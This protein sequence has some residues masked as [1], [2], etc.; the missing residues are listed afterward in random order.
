MPKVK[1]SA[2]QDEKEV[3]GS[4]EDRECEG[5]LDPRARKHFEFKL[6]VSLLRVRIQLRKRF[7]GRVFETVSC[8]QFL[9]FLES[10][11]A[12]RVYRFT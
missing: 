10:F 3:K 9:C 4:E 8:Q 2:D 11:V 1:P 5:D 7:I 12:F 6:R